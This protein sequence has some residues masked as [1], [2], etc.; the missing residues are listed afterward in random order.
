MR[1]K[2]YFIPAFALL[3]SL[4]AAQAPPAAG[5]VEGVSYS[6]GAS[7]SVFNPD[8]GCGGLGAFASPFSCS[9][10]AGTTGGLLIGVVPYV[11]SGFFAFRRIGFEGEARLMLF[12]GPL[13]MVQYS[14]LGGPRFRIYR[15]KDLY[16]SGKF[17]IGSGHLDVPS[18]ALGSGNYFVFAPG[19]AVDVPVTTNVSARIGY[20]YQ[21]WPGYPSW[22][23]HGGGLNPNGF[24]FGINY[25][26]PSSNPASY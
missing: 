3:S 11:D 7:V 15:Y 18:P 23:G 17:L 9:P 5:G 2:F 1:K 4:L 24:D 19:A 6:V 21:V 22:Q 12:H 16:V 10:R 20:E 13:D 25:R 14:F 26:I 8:Y